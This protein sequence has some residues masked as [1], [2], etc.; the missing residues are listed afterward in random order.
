MLPMAVEGSA[1]CLI[2]DN[3]LYSFSGI[4]IKAYKIID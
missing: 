3:L 4:N 1:V 2:D